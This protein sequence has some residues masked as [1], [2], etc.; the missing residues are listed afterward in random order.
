MGAEMEIY[1]QELVW[2]EVGWN[3]LAYDRDHW[4]AGVNALMNFKVP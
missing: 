4:R 3:R 2:E 1:L